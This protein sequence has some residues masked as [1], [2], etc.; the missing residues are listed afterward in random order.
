MQGTPRDASRHVFDNEKWAHVVRVA[1]FAISR[2]A[3][4]NGEYR[5]FIE[6]QLRLKRN[7]TAIYQDLVESHGF[8]HAYNSVKRFVSR[9]KASTLAKSYAEPYAARAP[10]SITRFSC[11]TTWLEL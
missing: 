4:T 7:A 8:T 5:D 1:P 3:V 10:N 2:R 9:L 11:G 6:A